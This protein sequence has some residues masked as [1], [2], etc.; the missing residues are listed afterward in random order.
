MSTLAFQPDADGTTRRD[1]G[2]PAT[3]GVSSSVRKR[4]PDK[5]AFHVEERYITYAELRRAAD[6]AFGPACGERHRGGGRR[7]A[8][9]PQLDR[10]R[11]GAARLL[12]PRGRGGASAAY[13]RR[14]AALGARCSAKARGLSDSGGRGDREVERLRGADRAG[15]GDRA[16]TT[17][18]PLVKETATDATGKR[19]ARTTWRCC[20]T[21]GATS[22]PKGIMHTV[23]TLRYPA[24]SC[25]CAGSSARPT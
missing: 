18:S 5:A 23:N 7:A 11:G 17:W 19:S 15:P 22:M 16:A 12:S 14:G 25:W 1:T 6:S 13:V 21:L 4:P 2:A 9:R 20:C 24:S 10:G 3:C 8:A